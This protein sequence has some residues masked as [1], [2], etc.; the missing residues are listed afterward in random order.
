[1]RSYRALSSLATFAERYE[2]LRIGGQVGDETF[3]AERWMNQR[4]YHSEEWR[5]IRDRVLIRDNGYDL[6]IADYP[7][8]SA[9]HVHHMNPI[10]ADQIA[11]GDDNVFDIDGLI[12]VSQKTHNA[13]HY[14]SKLSLPTP[15]SGREPGDTDWW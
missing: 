8:V 3:G 5:R 4:F 2:Y 15:F 1:M 13:I 14:G 11:H 6:G 10:T 7:I 12:T 9:P